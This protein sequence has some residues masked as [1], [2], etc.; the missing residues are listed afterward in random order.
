MISSKF[1][2]SFRGGDLV[3]GELWKSKKAEKSQKIVKHHQVTTPKTLQKLTW[4]HLTVFWLNFENNRRFLF[5]LHGPTPTYS[6]NRLPEWFSSG[7]L[8]GHNCI[9]QLFAVINH[10]GTLQSGHY[11]CFIKQAQ[12]SWFKCDDSLV[13]KASID[14]VLRSEAYLLFYHKQTESFK[15]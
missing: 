10:Q 12:N 3:L 2:K 11:T 4:N 7:Q 8:S 14:E 6:W 13:T 5:V 1:L 9:F 15:N